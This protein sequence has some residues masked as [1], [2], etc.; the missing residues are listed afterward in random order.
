[1]GLTNGCDGN[2]NY[3]PEGTLTYGQLAKLA[4]LARQVRDGKGLTLTCVD[5]DCNNQI[6]PD[7]PP[8]DIF[9]AYIQRT[10]RL[11]N[12]Q[13]APP[14]ADG[15]PY[16]YTPSPK[17]QFC[18]NMTAPRGQFA[19]YLVSLVMN[20]DSRYLLDWPGGGGLPAVQSPNSPGS[21]A[22][23][24]HD[25]CS[26]QTTVEGALQH[27]NEFVVIGG[28]Q[29]ARSRTT[30]NPLLSPRLYTT[31][32]YSQLVRQDPLPPIDL[33][34]TGGSSTAAV[35]QTQV[36][37]SDAVQMTSQ[38]GVISGCLNGVAQPDMVGSLRSTVAPPGQPL[39][40]VITSSP[41]GIPLTVDGTVCVSPCSFQWDP[42]LPHTISAPS[43]QAGGMGTQYRFVTWSDG[44]AITHTVTA[45]SAASNFT[46]N[47]G[48]WYLLSL[49][50]T[51]A[52][53][54]SI[55]ASPSSGDGYYQSGT[56][57]QVSATPATGR[58]F[59]GFSGSLSGTANP[60][61]LAMTALMSVTASFSSG[62]PPNITGI[63]PTS[64]AVG[65]PV[66]I[67]G[68]DFGTSGSVSFAGTPAQQIDLWTPTAVVARV[69][70]GATTGFISITTGGLQASFQV[71]QFQVSPVI[72]TVSPTSAT[73][74]PG[75]TQQ[76][77][78]TVTGTGNQEVTWSVAPTGAWSISS[79][80]LFTAPTT[81]AAQQIVTI[82]ATSVAEQTAKGNATV[83]MNP[84]T[85]TITNLS[86][87]SGPPQVGFVISGANF[88]ST[89]GTVILTGLSGGDRQLTVITWSPL[90]V[91]VPNGTPLGAGQVYV[92][93]STGATSNQMPF[94]VK[95]PFGC[96][97]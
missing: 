23:D 18:E 28:Y 30:I 93:T 57:V 91:Q 97:F 96:N 20:V 84:P 22:N 83:T 54:G 4:V 65:T 47:F 55:A 12:E 86:L 40:T 15:C 36:S 68:T 74:G 71:Q 60:Q 10:Y 25:T 1:L 3:C 7:V 45:T 11:L 41:V 70:P 35:L 31:Y 29:F 44:G 43:V 61:T 49:A 16:V 51:P 59:L 27:V 92:T 46:A 13:A 66:T 85:P 26:V 2:G 50:V 89:Q 69:P 34:M 75:Q 56:A 78:S 64:G 81:I 24:I 80:G 58:Q 52:G 79:T 88:G 48:T 82:T 94:T 8:G 76:F 5:Y 73:L 95:E 32:L 21:G 19:I 14:P 87:G 39:T 72:V 37:F 62:L 67:T 42:G 9:Y 77:T 6:Y 53:A 63:S 17:R 33:E 90:A 38:H